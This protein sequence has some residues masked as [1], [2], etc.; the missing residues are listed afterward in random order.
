[1]GRYVRVLSGCN[2]SWGNLLEMIFITLGSQKFQFNRLL[3]AVDELVSNGEITDDVFA[4]TGYSYYEPQKYNFK[5]FLSRDE[6]ADIISETDIVITHGGT[7]AIVGAI[8]AGKKVIAIPRLEKFGEHVDDHQQ[9]IVYQ[10]KKSDLICG[11]DEC[12]E[13]VDAIEYSKNHDFKKYESNTQTI[14][15]SIENFINKE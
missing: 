13:L 6:F 2:L 8:K 7:G 3:K 15:E 9:Q 5:Q 4:Q 14:I 11:I 1:M 12:D 10:F